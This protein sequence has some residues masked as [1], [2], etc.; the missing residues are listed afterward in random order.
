MHPLGPCENQRA[1]RHK[2][3][4]ECRFHLTPFPLGVMVNQLA[5]DQIFLQYVS[6]VILASATAY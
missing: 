3:T 2:V 1:P 6:S 5:L 4:L